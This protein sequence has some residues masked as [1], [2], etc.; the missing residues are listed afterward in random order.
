MFLKREALEQVC[1]LRGQRQRK[2]TEKKGDNRWL[3]ALEGCAPQRGLGEG[4]GS[5]WEGNPLTTWGNEDRN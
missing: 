2:R 1:I 3:Q 5:E 4:V